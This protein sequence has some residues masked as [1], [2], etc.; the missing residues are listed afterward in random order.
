MDNEIK[1]YK[2]IA[3]LIFTTFSTA[4]I[5]QRNAE[6][7]D[8]YFENNLFED[9]I[10]YYQLELKK[11]STDSKRYALKQLAECYRL[12]GNFEEAEDTYR[13]ILKS[14]KNQSDAQNYLNYG[15]SLKSSAKFDEAKVQFESYINLKPD[16]KLGPVYLSSC[17]SAQNWLDKG[18]GKTATNMSALNTEE[19]D[20]SPV[21]LPNNEIVFTSSRDGST[22][23]LISFNGGMKINHLDLYQISLDS[24]INGN[25]T[26]SKYPGINSAK[27]EG[28][29]CFTKD[30]KEIYLTQTVKG[31]KN[32]RTGK[33]VNVLQILHSTY[34]DSL[35]TWSIPSSNCD[36][37]ALNY[38][39]CHPSL[40]VNEDTLFFVSDKKGGYGGTDLY[41]ATKNDKGIWTEPINLGPDVNTYGHELFPTMAMDGKLYFSS[42][43]HPG[44]GRLDIF[45]T[46]LDRGWW[47]PPINLATPINSIGDDF[48]ITL[49]EFGENG[50]FSSDRF[51]GV[52]KD[53]IYS[54]TFEAPLQIVLTKS[55]FNFRNNKLFDGL[56]YKLT[57]ADSLTE[58][59]LSLEGNKFYGEIEKGT[60][61]KIAVRKVFFDVHSLLI[62]KL[63]TA[64]NQY[65]LYYLE[66]QTKS[67]VI[68][69]KELLSEYNSG[70][71]IL[72]NSNG[73]EII[74]LNAKESSSKISLDSNE[75][76]RLV[77]GDI[78]SEELTEIKGSL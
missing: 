78:S 69:L 44:M 49:D 7:G 61:Y 45:Y 8:R 35:K 60:N 26:V 24:L 66:P 40:S 11:G 51:N 32:K 5:G 50:F 56:T 42:D 6:K 41:Y 43:G 64:S 54:F 4:L 15:Q 22:E 2:I 28:P 1:T 73:D 72:I 17:D 33:I 75:S 20:F 55:G 67:Y 14:K 57:D 16:D 65:Q 52:G 59:P 23:A 27:H 48:G 39:I 9:A 37:N 12:T 34:D 10:N 74:N 77:I 19:S 36:F 30:M 76:Y 58:L 63:T 21:L 13:K 53:D 3:L 31:E 46:K 62:S 25:T 29:M 47:D 18:L 68:N 38:S 70:K 71:V